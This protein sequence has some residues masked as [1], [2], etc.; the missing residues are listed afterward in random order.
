MGVPVSTRLRIIAIVGG[1]LLATVGMASPASAQSWSFQDEARD[2]VGFNKSN[3]NCA[4][5]V[6]DET[7]TDGDI[8]TTWV[9]H[10]T[11]KLTVKTHF[12]TLTKPN[13]DGAYAFNIATNEDNVYAVF[14]GAGGKGNGKSLI[15]DK[16]KGK[17]FTCLGLKTHV[18][19]TADTI[20]VEI[21][22]LCLSNPYWVVIGSLGYSRPTTASGLDAYRDAMNDGLAFKR[23]PK[24]V[25]G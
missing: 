18:D 24:L 13:G 19:Y 6:R 25:R 8:R 16:K 4:K 11:K 2:M 15:L 23:T 7:R 17:Y 14:T 9:D 12:T 10:T 20:G 22:R 21:P 5:C 1:L 3:P